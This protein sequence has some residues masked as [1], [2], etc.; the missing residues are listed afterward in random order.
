[1]P[2][3]APIIATWPVRSADPFFDILKNEG[4]NVI[5]MPL[6]EIRCISFSFPRPQSEYNWLVFTSKNGI[7]CFLEKHSF[8]GNNKIAVIGE[9]TANELRLNG[10][11]PHF[12]GSGGLGTHFASELDAVIP[13]KATVLMVMG[14]LAPDVIKNHLTGSRQVDRVN[15]YETAFPEHVDPDVVNRIKRGDYAVIAVSSPSIVRHLKQLAGDSAALSVVSIGA[16]TTAAARKLDIE[17]VATASHRS[18]EGLA[19]TVINCIEKIK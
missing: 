6:I 5:S 18:Y 8:N 7:R 12:V 2:V 10:V 17:P 3:N 4:L 16:T 14:N 1:M 13:A 11:E 15:S 9:P 19:E